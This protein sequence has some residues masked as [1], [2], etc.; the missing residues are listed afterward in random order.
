MSF[1]AHHW[2][3]NVGLGISRIYLFDKYLTSDKRCVCECH[4]L[5]SVDICS[6]PTMCTDKRKTSAQNQRIKKNQSNQNIIFFSVPFFTVIS[7]IK[8]KSSLCSQF[9][10]FFFVCVCVRILCA[11]WNFNSF[12][13][14]FG[15]RLK[16]NPR[17]IADILSLERQGVGGSMR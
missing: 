3:C 15:K 10:N 17:I 1:G 16:T 11:I 7:E 2:L 9:V 5:P 12:F 6:I 14:S 4:L 13:A 8:S